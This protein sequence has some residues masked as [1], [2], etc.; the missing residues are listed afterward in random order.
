MGPCE[1]NDVEKGS[2][3]TKPS[4]SQ[5]LASQL[6]LHRFGLL[7]TVFRLGG[8]SEAWFLPFLPPFRVSVLH[9]KPNDVTTASDISRLWTQGDSF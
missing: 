1:S 9:C 3:H 7:G 4:V 8:Y 6:T 5:E 2:T